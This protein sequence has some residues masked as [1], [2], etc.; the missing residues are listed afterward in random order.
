M[1]LL[2]DSRIPNEYKK[3][4]RWALCVVDTVVQERQDQETR[5]QE[6]LDHASQVVASWPNW[7]RKCLALNKSLE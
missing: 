2:N 7:K 1:Y 3:A 5:F 6:F 4:V